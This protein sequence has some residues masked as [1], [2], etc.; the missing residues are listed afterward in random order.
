MLGQF[1]LI[2]IYREVGVYKKERKGVGIET[3]KFKEEETRELNWDQSSMESRYYSL[4][5][6][7][8]YL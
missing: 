3:R 1:Q 4:L 5:Q 6:A 7:A 2:L 8:F